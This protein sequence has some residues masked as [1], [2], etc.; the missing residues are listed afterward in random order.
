MRKKNYADQCR[1]YLKNAKGHLKVVL[2]HKKE[3]MKGCFK[4]GL[5]WQGIIH[6]LSKFSPTEFRT[7]VRYFQG[8]RSPNA[9]ERELLGYS[10][11]WLHHKGRNRHH[12]EYWTD[13]SE[14]KTA[15][16]AG[17]KMPPRYLAEMVMDR[18]AAS[19][20]YRGADYKDSDNLDYLMRGRDK[21]TMHPETYAELKHILTILSE[22]GETAMFLYVKRLLTRNYY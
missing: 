19:K 14:D 2:H 20:T 22:H 12:F 13:V 1:L 15:C 17:K 5:Y 21:E 9:R 18:I 8:T 7:G 16:L 3:V 6:D 11:A 4:V 10:T